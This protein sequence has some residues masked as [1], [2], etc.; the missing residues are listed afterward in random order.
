MGSSEAGKLQRSGGSAEVG[1]WLSMGE[2][3]GKGDGGGRMLGKP[4]VST[5]LEEI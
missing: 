4:Q 2:I 3:G 1:Q 5:A